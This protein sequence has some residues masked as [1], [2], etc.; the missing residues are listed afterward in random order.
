MSGL[1]QRLRAAAREARQWTLARLRRRQ[2]DY[3]ALFETDL[4]RRVLRD[5][6]RANHLGAEALVLA[7]FEPL[8]AA[9]IRGRQA[10]VIEVA[11]KIEM[12]E[13]D[14]HR[15]ATEASYHDQAA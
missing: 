4:G 8:Q 7:G 3:R 13:A 15:L 6:A 2:A 5:M 14:L 12:S 9:Y 10:A 11:M 1:Q